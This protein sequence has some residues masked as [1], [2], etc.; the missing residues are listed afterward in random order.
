MHQATSTSRTPIPATA[1]T[2]RSTRSSR[3]GRRGEQAAAAYLEE[4]GYRIL[5]RNWR[6][7]YADQRGELDLVLR[8]RG[9]LVVCEVKARTGGPLAHPAEAVTPEKL[10]RLRRLA[11]LWLREHARASAHAVGHS[12]TGHCATGHRAAG[13]RGVGDRGVGDRGVGDRGAAGGPAAAPV[14]GL[15]GALRAVR[16]RALGDRAAAGHVAAGR[17]APVLGLL[18]A[19]RGASRPFVPTELRIDVVAVRLGPREPFPVLSVEHLRGVG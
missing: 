14:F 6:S 9:A 11:A 2:A 7:P 17:A 12:A 4:R 15:L 3:V 13:D 18:G 8:H 10:A 5:D 16:D 1:A 19:L